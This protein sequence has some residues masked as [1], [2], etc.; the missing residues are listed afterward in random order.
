MSMAVTITILALALAAIAG[1]VVFAIKSR[2]SWTEAQKD[3]ARAMRV[4]L[5]LI[6][7]TGC[8]LALP[9]SKASRPTH[10]DGTPYRY[11]EIAAEGWGHCDGCHQWGQWTPES[12]HECTQ[13]QHVAVNVEG[14]PAVIGAEVARALRR[15]GRG[16]S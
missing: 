5:A 16:N 4:T 2:T 12:P 1:S 3:Q 14:D 8:G 15:Y 7:E 9:S 11:H 13:E 10:P 6:G